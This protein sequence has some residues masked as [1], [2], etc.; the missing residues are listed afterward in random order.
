MSIHIIVC[1]KSVVRAVTGGVAR[2]TPENSEFNP[3]DRSALE[4]AL[5]G[6]EA[7]G[8][9][10]TVL[11]VGPPVA[12]ATLAE[13]LAMGADQ[14]VLVSDPAMAG[15]DTLVTSRILAKAINRMTPFDF[16]FF[17][18]RTS[19]S[20]TGQVGPQTTTLLD[21]PFLSGVKKLKPQRDGWDVHRIM[22]KWEEVWQ[23][24][25]PAAMTIDSRA[26][27]PRPVGLLGLGRVYKQPAI[28]TWGLTDLELVAQ[29]VGL[30]GSPTRVASMQTTQR[31]RKCDML[32]GEPQEQ[33]NTL[34]ERLTNA[35]VMGS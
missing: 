32:D 17:G 21:I 3:F 30:A 26:F 19:D 33:V 10:V 15:S 18:T 5:Q 27:R 24:Q 28:Q 31:K 12:A 20:D 11:S 16:V 6:K 25:S 9:S 22:D 23:M 14:A 34:I 29:N 8:G 13:A 1:I 4:A 35:G 2:R 7:M